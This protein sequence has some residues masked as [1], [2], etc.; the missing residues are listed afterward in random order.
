MALPGMAYT[1]SAR[2]AQAASW[3]KGSDCP[4]LMYR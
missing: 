2:V 1:A 3:V 4:G